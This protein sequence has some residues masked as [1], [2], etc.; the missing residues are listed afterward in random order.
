VTLTTSFRCS[1]VY[2]S[3]GSFVQSEKV[4]IL[5]GL[6]TGRMWVYDYWPFRMGRSGGR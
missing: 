5:V 1:V 6:D 3:I 2:T 4:V